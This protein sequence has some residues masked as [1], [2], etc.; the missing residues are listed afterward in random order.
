[1]CLII[2]IAIRIKTVL[3][4]QGFLALDAAMQEDE[5]LK[6]EMAGT[7]AISII[8]KNQKLYCVS[9]SPYIQ[10]GLHIKISKIILK[11]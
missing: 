1:M 10:L 4:F 7:T 11:M 6:D 9:Y 8:V 5:T 3:F 2:G